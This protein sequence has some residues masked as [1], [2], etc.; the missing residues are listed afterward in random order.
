VGE[1]LKRKM[2][3][4]TQRAQDLGISDLSSFPHLLEF[5]TLRETGGAD[6]SGQG[7]GGN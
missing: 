5:T 7:A 2:P 4:H 3:L 1:E 6:G